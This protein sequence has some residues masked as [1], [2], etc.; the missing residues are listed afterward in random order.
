[1]EHHVRVSKET[2]QDLN[3]RKEPTDSFNDVI[4]RLLDEVNDP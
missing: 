2:W 1:M 3:A 4:R